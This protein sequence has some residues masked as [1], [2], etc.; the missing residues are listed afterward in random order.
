MHYLAMTQ[1]EVHRHGIIQKLIDKELNGTVASSI[2]K[3]SV[4]QVQR[5]KAKMLEGGV[6][7]LIHRSRGKPS[8]RKLPEAERN[9][10][11]TILTEQYPDFGPTFASEKLQEIHHIDKDVKTIRA[12]MIAEELWKPKQ[13]KKRAYHSWRQRKDC[14]GQM[15][16]FDGS[17]HNWFEGRAERLDYCL[18]ASID[19][20]TGVPTKAKFDDS[21]GIFPVFS[22]WKEYVKQYGK[23]QSIYLDKFSTYKMNQRVA[24]E[25]HDTQTQFQRAMGQLGIEPITA[26]SPQAKGRIERLFHTFQDRLVKELRLRNINTVKEAN[27]FLEN[28]FLPDYA[29]KYG[30][31]P[32]HPTNLH[33][34][35]SAKE[36]AGLESI[37]SRHDTRVVRNDFT[38]SFK[39]QWYQLSENQLVTI[40][41]KD[42]IGVE[43]RLD[44][45]IH[46]TLR[47][48]YLHCSII[49]ESERSNKALPIP[50]VIPARRKAHTPAANHPWRQRFAAPK[51]SNV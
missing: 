14:F 5:L 39:N 17:Y 51:L 38:V 23:P 24:M 37:F 1:K 29:Q 2:L 34:S 41:K 12:I 44:G 13:K 27:H 42:T 21:E 36:S 25:N 18:L 46:F 47:S 11:A 49:T 22:F 20:A 45:T 35:L 19:D 16:Q 10:I 28:T 6:A 30:V 15:Q 9:T 40:R 31:Q 4:R 43:E 3:L 26:H 8:N 32:K 50:W 7:A 33:Q 48:T